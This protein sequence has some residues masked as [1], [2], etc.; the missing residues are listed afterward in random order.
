MMA[1]S[2]AANSRK[3]C[4]HLLYFV[5]TES[6]HLGRL[7]PVVMLRDVRKRRVRT[8]KCYPWINSFSIVIVASRGPRIPLALILLPHNPFSPPG[9]K[10]V[11]FRLL[12]S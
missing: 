2:L 6:E 10:P 12:I 7:K 1:T 4:L 5:K 11:K 3:G 9:A 8:A